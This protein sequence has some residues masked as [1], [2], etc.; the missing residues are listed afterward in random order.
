MKSAFKE[1]GF[2]L[3]RVTEEREI[4]AGARGILLN[5]NLELGSD[6]VKHWVILLKEGR[7]WQLADSI[8]GV[9]NVDSALS[10]NTIA[11]DWKCNGIFE[12]S[13]KPTQRFGNHVRANAFANVVSF[14]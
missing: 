9:F 5:C 3:R 4:C 13:A 8:S 2:E 12:I 10:Y 7:K 1:I 14:L 11:K 6:V